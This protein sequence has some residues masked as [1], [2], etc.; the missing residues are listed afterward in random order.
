MTYSEVRSLPLTYRRWF[1]SRLIKHFE[2][3]NK[4]KEDSVQGPPPGSI[5]DA[6]TKDAKR[7]NEMKKIDKILKK[8]SQ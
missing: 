6:Y 7:K 2:L 8:F 3:K 5:S 1:L 4:K